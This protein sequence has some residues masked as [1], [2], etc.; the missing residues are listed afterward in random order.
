MPSFSSLLFGP[1]TSAGSTSPKSFTSGMSRTPKRSSTASCIRR[2]SRSTS[3]ALAPPRLTMKF[4]CSVE[5]CAPPSVRPLSAQAS[6]SRP[7]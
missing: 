7:A 5:I 3:A 4:A 6:M 2:M 1:G